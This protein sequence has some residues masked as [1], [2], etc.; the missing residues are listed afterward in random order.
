MASPGVV[1][2]KW[3][4][5]LNTN[6]KSK[7]SMAFGS[8]VPVQKLNSFYIV[9][10]TT[11]ATECYVFSHGG[12]FDED[13]L[14]DN[15]SF[16]IPNEVIVEFYQPDGYMIKYTATRIRNGR[17]AKASG[18]FT[19][20]QFTAGDECPNYILS[21]NQGRHQAVGYQTADSAQWEMDYAGVQSVAGDTD[22]VI[23]TIRNRWFHAGVTLK[24]AI[25]A[26][27]KAAPSIKTFH[28][29]FCR[30]RDG[31][32]DWAWTA[33]AAGPGWGQ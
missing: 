28:C 26:V 24:E 9:G 30:V 11:G 12:S 25:K 3:A 23:V 33:N 15:R 2:G 19:D 21:K 16:T 18:G 22:T 1:F 7:S 4:T 8:D 10:D 31:Y 20:M 27:R 6:I 5:H 29:M 14:L 32:D 17:P 13:Y